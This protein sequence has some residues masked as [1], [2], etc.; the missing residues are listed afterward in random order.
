M[1]GERVD[2][3]EKYDL[4]KTKMSLYLHFRHKTRSKS[5][6][7]VKS[8]SNWLR[9]DI[10]SKKAYTKHFTLLQEQIDLGLADNTWDKRIY[11]LHR[12]GVDVGQK[13]LSKK[14]LRDKKE[15]LYEVV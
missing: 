2:L 6:E 1:Y 15:V 7:R 13:D 12:Q 11:N 5:H 14:N 4:A 10:K 3:T 9:D 8:N